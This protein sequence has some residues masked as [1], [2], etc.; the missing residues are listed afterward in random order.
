MS[1]TPENA[2]ANKYIRSLK[3][4]VKRRFAVSYLAWIRGGRK[5]DVPTRGT[6]APALAK[7]V[8]LN[9]DALS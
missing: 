9:L 6:L 3:D 5:G 7:A 1:N 4:A 2:E 8:C